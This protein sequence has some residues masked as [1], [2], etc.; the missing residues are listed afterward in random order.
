MARMRRVLATARAALRAAVTPIETWSSLLA[1]VGIESTLAGWASDLF[2]EA[3][4]AA[5]TWA[6]IRPGLQAAVAGE[7]RGQAGQRGVHEPLDAPLADGA[8]LGHRDGE[9]VGGHRHRLAVE[10]AARE[11]LAGLGED[12][13]VVGGGVHLDA[14]PCAST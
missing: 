3:R 8:Q 11:Q 12:H 5:V 6:I 1:E 9:Q 2:S 10:V 14:R 7:E 13:R 4:A